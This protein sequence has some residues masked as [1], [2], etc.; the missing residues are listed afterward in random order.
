MCSC[1]QSSH[2]A[3]GHKKTN[4]FYAQPRVKWKKKG[5]DKMQTIR[6]LQ[7]MLNFLM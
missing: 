4:C 2:A 7:V 6:D 1:V 3:L 5:N